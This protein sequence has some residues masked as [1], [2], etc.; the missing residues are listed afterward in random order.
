MSEKLTLVNSA[1]AAQRIGVSRSTLQRMVNLGQL[2][3]VGKGPG[4]R[5]AYLFDAAD[6]DRVAD[7]KGAALT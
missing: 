2:R 4:L 6:I 5:G 1:D 3:P 7:A